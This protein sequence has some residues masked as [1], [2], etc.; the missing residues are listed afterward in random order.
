MA[1]QELSLTSRLEV[2]SAEPLAQKQLI[3]E[4]KVDVSVQHIA[5]LMELQKDIELTDLG[6]LT[7]T[8]MYT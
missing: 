4:G 2:L 8:I 6:M 3:E 7:Q 5:Y 1:L